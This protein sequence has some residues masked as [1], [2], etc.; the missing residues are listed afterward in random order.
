MFHAEKGF[1][2]RRRWST[3]IAGVSYWQKSSVVSGPWS[4]I[5]YALPYDGQAS[6][7]PYPRQTDVG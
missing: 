2:P 5:Y 3:G 1:V 7:L 6:I 4:L